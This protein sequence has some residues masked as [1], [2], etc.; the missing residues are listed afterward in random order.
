MSSIPRPAQPVR[1]VLVDDQPL[2]RAG[3]HLFLAPHEGFEVVGEADHGGEAL[4]LLARV[5]CDVVVMDVRMPV[6]DGIEATRRIVAADGPPVLVL[7]TFGENETLVDALDAGAAGFSLKSAPPES[8][9]D[10][11]RA[12]AG[13]GAWIDPVLLPDLLEQY[14]RV[15]IPRRRGGQAVE[16]LTPREHDVLVLIASAAS[17]AEIADQLFVGESTVKSH[18]SSIFMKLGV[19]DR[20]AAIVYAFDRG[21]VSPKLD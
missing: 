12:T 21:I 8:L 16:E 14:R 18:I 5:D 20:A 17:N 9:I 6:M 11:V 15:A 1:L 10:A 13:G 3:L 19:R 2:I 7:T 4:D